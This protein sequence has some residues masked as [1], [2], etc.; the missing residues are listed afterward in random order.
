MQ[1]EI[2]VKLSMCLVQYRE[3]TTYRVV[4]VEPMDSR[5]IRPVIA[6]GQ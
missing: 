1:V 3:I 2:K 5:T 4:Q 6:E